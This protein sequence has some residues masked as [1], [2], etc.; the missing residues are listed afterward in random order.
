MLNNVSNREYYSELFEDY[1]RGKG[2]IDLLHRSANDNVLNDK[3][4]VI[5]S[6]Q[7]NDSLQ[8]SD[9]LQVHDTLQVTDSFK[10]LTS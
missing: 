7:L 4:D 3:K 2:L 10:K 6:L 9:S 5:K 1:L 8:A